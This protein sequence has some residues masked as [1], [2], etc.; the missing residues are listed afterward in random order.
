MAGE[1]GLVRW[2]TP[3]RVERRDSII[4]SGRTGFPSR[5]C[6]TERVQHAKAADVHHLGIEQVGDLQ[7]RLLLSLEIVC[8]DEAQVVRSQRLHCDRKEQHPE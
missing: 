4:V 3:G 5:F 7:L 2:K 1:A 8:F 6:G